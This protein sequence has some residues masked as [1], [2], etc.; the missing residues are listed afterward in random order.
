MGYL[1]TAV[2]AV[3]VAVFAMQ[4]TEHV[5]V[6]FLVWQ[7]ADVPVAAVVLASFGFG[8]LA[9]GIPAWFKVW[10]LRRRLVRAQQQTALPAEPSPPPP[11]GSPPP[12]VRT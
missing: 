12:S 5:A 10:R 7:I 3:A 9:A 11:P 6:N 1:V 2:V 8:V 4:N